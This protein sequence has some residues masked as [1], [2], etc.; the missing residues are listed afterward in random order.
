MESHN[1]I[2]VSRSVVGDPLGQGVLGEVAGGGRTNVVTHSAS[3]AVSSK[4][5]RFRK[6]LGDDEA[7]AFVAVVERVIARNPEGVARREPRDR[8]FTVD[9][10]IA[11]TRKCGLQGVRDRGRRL[12]RRCPASRRSWMAS[13]TS[14]STPRLAR[15]PRARITSE[16]ASAARRF[17]MVL[18]GGGHQ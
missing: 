2:L 14:R 11:W 9:K 16:F 6:Q 5:F 10:L 8:L 13:R 4:P 12:G 18:R 7:R 15:S 1:P 3:V 17:F